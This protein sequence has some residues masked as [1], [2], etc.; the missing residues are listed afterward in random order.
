MPTPL[1]NGWTVLSLRPRG[2][3]ASLRAASARAGARLL[4]LSPQA[5]EMRCDAEAALDAALTC[6]LLLFTSPNAV[7]AASALR[8]FKPRRG[9]PWLAV[10]EGTR[11]ALSRIGID[12]HSP[13]RMDSEGLLAMPQLQAIAGKR[14]GLV[15]APGGRG[16][17]APALQKRGAQVLRA[18]VYARVPVTVP[19]QAW[20]R[21]QEA[22]ATP[23]KTL[24]MLSSAEALHALLAQAPASLHA[25]LHRVAVV[26]ASGRLAQAAREAG[27][28]RIVTATDARPASLL[29][30]A[31][32]TF[33]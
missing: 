20:V 21:L 30:A 11:R 17:L 25:R 26:A 32:D 8:T 23:N 7:R 22:L 18:D 27:F 16:A 33:V 13:T 29:R 31:I 28:R 19:P 24:L 4:A 3:H 10:G 15:T 9:Q 6:D 12:A 1:L 2:Q 5:I 14:I